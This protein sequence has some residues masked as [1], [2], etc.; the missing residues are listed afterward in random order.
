MC[1]K[2]IF[3][4]SIEGGKRKHGYK[5]QIPKGKDYP[6]CSR[7]YNDENPTQFYLQHVLSEILTGINGR[8]SEYAYDTNSHSVINKDS[9][10]SQDFKKWIS[11]K[12][13]ANLLRMYSLNYDRIFKILLKDI[14]IECFEGFNSTGNVSDMEGIR[15]DVPRI[16][17]NLDS[18]IF[19]NLHGSAFWKVL[20]KN[21]RQLP[22]PE[23][24]YTGTPNLPANDDL[25]N[26]RIEKGKPLYLTNIITGY[27]KA[28]KSMISPFKQMHFAFDRDCF[29]ANKIYI[30]GYSFGDEHIN[31]CIKIALRH[32][33]NL[34]LEIIDPNFIKNK[35]DEKLLLTLFQYIENDHI[36]PKKIGNNK[37]SYY[38]DRIIVY[39]LKFGEYLKVKSS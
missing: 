32:N 34:I 27:Q 11:S 29:V 7:S 6:F 10:L 30:I 24:V 31:E 4:F 20:A 13:R 26:V 37:F 25:S 21:G 17:K 2:K 14:G 36:Y 35:F 22:E 33:E 3:D 12:E 5:L 18:N 1:L 15:C 39:T 28:Q 9:T 38:S 19:Y 23:I 16:L 8:I